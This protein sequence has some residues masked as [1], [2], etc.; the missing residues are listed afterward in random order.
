MQ[1]LF[2]KMLRIFY[3]SFVML[4]FSLENLVV[5]NMDL[6]LEDYILM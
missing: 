6:K 3:A 4:V 1:R 5:L 2:T